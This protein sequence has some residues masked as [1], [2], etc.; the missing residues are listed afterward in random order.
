VLGRPWCWQ[1]LGIGLGTNHLKKNNLLSIDKDIYI[2]IFLLD[3]VFRS[4]QRDF[5]T[6]AQDSIPIISPKYGCG[7]C[8]MVCSW[9]YY[10]LVLDYRPFHNNNNNNITPQKKKKSKSVEWL[11]GWNHNLNQTKSPNTQTPRTTI[12]VKTQLS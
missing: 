4:T 7:G 11:N 10:Y 3:V 5:Q 2:Y 9:Y 1:G 12:T 6:I 8:G